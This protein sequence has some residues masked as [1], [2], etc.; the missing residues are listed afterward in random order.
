MEADGIEKE[1]QRRSPRHPYAYPKSKRILKT[2]DYR[3]I[4]DE[5]KRLSNREFLLFCKEGAQANTRIGISV[6]KVVG[7]AAKRNYYKRILRE[8]LRTH[9]NKLLS[10]KDI[11]VVA[12]KEILNQ[13][14]GK[15]QE[16]LLSLFKKADLIKS[17]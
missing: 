13:S 4:Y 16:S 12:K 3:Q 2:S 8:I 14:F 15:I 1:V 10:G 9:Y 6:S 5:G 11:V 17:I 7:K